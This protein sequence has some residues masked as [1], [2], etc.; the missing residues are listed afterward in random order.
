M[1]QTGCMLF[2]CV[3]GTTCPGLSK[4]VIRQ[5]QGLVDSSALCTEVLTKGPWV[6]HEG[7]YA[8]LPKRL[9]VSLLE[10]CVLTAFWSFIMQV[11]N[12]RYAVLWKATS[13]RKTVSLLPMITYLLSLFSP[14]IWHWT[15]EGIE[16]T[17]LFS[18]L[19][20]FY[21]LWVLT[22]RIPF[23]FTFLS[24]NCHPVFAF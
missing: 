14:F 21:L 1:Q 9:Q 2:N 8:Y 17:H 24:W 23:F 16:S 15:F 18:S 7:S 11:G 6:S 19:F 10:V 20:L 13:V 22:H 12:S 5:L 3:C 4:V